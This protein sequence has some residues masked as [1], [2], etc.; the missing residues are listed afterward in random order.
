MTPG[1]A[2]SRSLSIIVTLE[3]GQV[4]IAVRQ[5][6]SPEAPIEVGQGAHDLRDDGITRNGLADGDLVV[7]QFLELVQNESFPLPGR[8]SGYGLEHAPQLGAINGS[9]FWGWPRVSYGK[10]IRVRKLDL[11]SLRRVPHMIEREIV[12]RCCK[13]SGNVHNMTAFDIVHKLY[14]SLLYE[15]FSCCFA[16][17]ETLDEPIQP[18]LFGGIQIGNVNRTG[19]HDLLGRALHEVTA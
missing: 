3:K 15:V 1:S 17:H 12:S 10:E 16:S 6:F 18:P 19:T 13:I 4:R 2:R 14:E 8:Q 7:G 9:R 11:G 5:L